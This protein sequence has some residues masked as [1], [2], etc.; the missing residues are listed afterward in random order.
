MLWRTID[1][2]R[3]KQ[4]IYN[5]IKISFGTTLKYKWRDIIV[6]FEYPKSIGKIRKDAIK[7]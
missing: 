1:F 4:I 7:K 3:I 6:D 5:S 2:E